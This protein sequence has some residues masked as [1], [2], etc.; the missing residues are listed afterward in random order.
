MRSQE[1]GGDEHA[2]ERNPKDASSGQNTGYT[3]HDKTYNA[4]GAVPVHLVLIIVGCLLFL[5][6]IIGFVS[7]YKAVNS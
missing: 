3:S 5:L 2:S 6:L 1:T 4:D 7:Y